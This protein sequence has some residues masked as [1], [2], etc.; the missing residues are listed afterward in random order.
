VERLGLLCTS[1]GGPGSSSYPLHELAQLSAEARA[2]TLLPLL[3]SRFT[4]EW[5]ATHP[6]D[7]ALVEMLAGRTGGTRSD[8]QRRGEAGQ[9]EARRHHDVSD[10][11]R[12]IACPTFVGAGRFDGIAPPANSE[13][14]AARVAGAELHVYEGGHAFLAQDRAAFPEILDFLAGPAT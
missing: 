12:Q 1:P 4:P 9:I 13:I 10:R 2:V 7:Q 11:L 8:E 3:D 5:L 14:I 6:A